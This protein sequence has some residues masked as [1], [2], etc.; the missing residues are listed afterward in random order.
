MAKPPSTAT[1]IALLIF[2][3]ALLAVSRLIDAE[4]TFIS[5]IAALLVVTTMLRILARALRG[6]KDAQTPLTAS[7]FFPWILGCTVG[8]VTALSLATASL[9]GILDTSGHFTFTAYVS[10]MV[11]TLLAILT[12]YEARR[13]DQ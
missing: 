6:E 8:A 3:G 12:R 4:S 11:L 5:V 10:A 13:Y 2:G 9:F 7:Y 1:L